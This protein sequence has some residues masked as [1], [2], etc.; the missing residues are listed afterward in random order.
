LTHRKKKKNGDHNDSD[1]D[2]EDAADLQVVLDELEGELEDDG[3]KEEDGN[4]EFDMR[5]EL[6]EGEIKELEAT[7]EPVQRVLTKVS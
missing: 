6:T 5:I 1:D 2:D 7:V 4:W 3:N